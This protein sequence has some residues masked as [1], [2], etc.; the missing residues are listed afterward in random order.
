M[1]DDSQLESTE[2]NSRTDEQEVKIST[3]FFEI[4][5]IGNFSKD[6]VVLEDTQERIQRP[7]WVERIIDQNWE[8]RK[9]EV[10]A[11]GGELVDTPKVLLLEFRQKA[12][13]LRLKLGRGSYR[14][15]VGTYDSDLGVNNPETVPRL[16]SVAALLETSDG[17]VVL[18]ERSLSVFQ[19]P[20]WLSTFG[21]SVE[22]EDT[23]ENGQIDPFK[24]AIKEISEESGLKQEVIGNVECLGLTKDTFTGVEDMLFHAKTVLTKEEIEREQKNKT[25]EEGRSIFV[26]CTPDEVRNKIL[27]FSK[28]FVSDG[29]ALLT[30]FGRRRFGEDWFNFVIDRLRRRGNVYSSLTEEQRK[31]LEQRLI[32]RLSRIR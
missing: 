16:F 29:S 32:E 14:D 12:G 10:E 5:I 3:P 1:P 15:F 9:G 17:F 8:K 26:P 23:S 11:R 30:L 2:N 31:I 19:N 7:A 22:L 27:E 4:P 25:L 28:V 6:D 20:H 18:N 24:T 21:G 13:K